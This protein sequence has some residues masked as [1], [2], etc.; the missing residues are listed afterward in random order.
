MSAEL[1]Q[2]KL[3]KLID[4]ETKVIQFSDLEQEA[5]QVTEPTIYE[6]HWDGVKFEFL[7]SRKPD[8]N[9]AVVF[10]TGDVGDNKGKY[11]FPIFS[12]GRWTGDLLCNGIWYFD[13]TVYLGEATLCWHYG[14][15]Q[16]W[17]L[18]DIAQIVQIILKKWNISMEDTVFSGSSGGGFSSIM[19][20]AMLRGKA[21]VINP[22]FIVTKFHAHLV[23]QFQNS[24][25]KH[26][27]TL[28]DERINVVSFFR[29]ANYFPQVYI[30]QNIN[31]THD[32]ETQLLPL[33]SELR[34]LQFN[35][36]E[37][38]HVEMYN[39]EGGHAS[40]PTKKEHLR[41]LDAIL[42]K[43]L[44]EMPVV[45]TTG[46]YVSNGKLLFYLDTGRELRADKDEIV[47]F[48]SLPTYRFKFQLIAD[49]VVVQKSEWIPHPFYAFDLPG[50]GTYKIKY[51][52]YNGNEREVYLAKGIRIVDGS[53]PQAM[54]DKAV[55]F[56]NDLERRINQLQES[57]V[58]T[59]YWIE[60]G[61]LRFSVENVANLC[62][63]NGVG[64]EIVLSKD[65]EITF[66][67]YLMQGKEVL[68][69]I[70]YGPMP[71]CAF[72]CPVNGVYR[73]KCYIKHGAEHRS[74]MVENIKVSCADN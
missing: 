55:Q 12:R 28:I 4:C 53:M 1:E 47:N 20:A 39:I 70:F 2:S 54:T 45:K 23:E 67:F 33:L 14:T 51:F 50:D 7:I 9:Q 48:F 17:Y 6:I 21:A 65:G 31:A 56:V 29:T 27:E 35:C 32:V 59:R 46:Y 43:P 74:F 40:Q 5:F 26:G 52:V 69:K 36:A 34:N 8:S 37:R 22:Q 30:K 66:A 71:S 16:R 19:L 3:K 44:L 62:M 10:G 18:E 72:H 57:T 61:M 15:N 42:E 13:P 49:N 64:E 63:Q 58:D 25:L 73:V 24:V 41:W 60:D 38:V 68:E 11:Q